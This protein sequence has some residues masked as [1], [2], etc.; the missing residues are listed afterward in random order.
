MSEATDVL[1]EA[2]EYPVLH[3]MP[4]SSDTGISDGVSKFAEDIVNLLVCSNAESSYEIGALLLLM[5]Y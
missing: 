4:S 2:K 1:D 3:C 5:A